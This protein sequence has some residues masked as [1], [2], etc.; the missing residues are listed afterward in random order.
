[1]NLRGA[2]IE[3]WRPGE[4]ELSGRTI[5]RLALVMLPVVIVTTNVIGAG[6]VVV[7][8]LFV[9]PL[10]GVHD[11]AHVRLV[12]ALVAAGYVATAVPLGVFLGTRGLWRLRTWLVEERPATLEEIRLVLYA[13]LRL[14]GLQFGLWSVAAILPSGVMERIG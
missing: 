1:M 14:F 7:L 10:P 13:P 6:A 4:G 2:L 9:V 11:P 8:G 12:D 5:W 3:L